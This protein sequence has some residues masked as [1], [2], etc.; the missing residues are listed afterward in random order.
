MRKI[1]GDFN[2]KSGSGRG[3]IGRRTLLKGSAA[4]AF[5]APYVLG[6]R[7]AWAADQ[8]VVASY[9]GGWAAAMTEAFHKPFTQETGVQVIVASGTD[10]AKAKAQVRTGNIEWDVV[11][12]SAGW[13]ATGVLDNMWERLDTSIIDLKTALPGTQ[14]EYGV[15]MCMSSG[16]IGW[17]TAKFP[18]GKHPVD[19]QGFWDV[20]KYPGRRGLMT[21]I[22]GPLEYALMADGVDPKK[23]Y[24][25]DIER[26]FKSLDKI[27]PHVTNWIGAMPQTITLLQAG[28][29][30][31]CQ[32]AAGRVFIAKKEG[33][34][35]AYASDSALVSPIYVSVLKGNKKKDLAMKHLAFQMRPDRQAHFAELTSYAPT[36]EAGMKLLSPA[37]L[38][39]SPDVTKP[40][41]AVGDEFWWADKFEELNKRYKEWQLT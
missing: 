30:D 36:T 4:L 26:G 22:A 38:A 32:T 24:P 21:R 12:L 8:L 7:R 39:L 10:L 15:G 19:W 33:A 13:L 41:V 18:A 37:T 17:N 2:V 29:V 34:P 3:L 6:S 5:A 16:G 31:F 28:E 14:H 27:K 9:G 11:E 25:L 40:G 35:V 20:K 23:L 1:P